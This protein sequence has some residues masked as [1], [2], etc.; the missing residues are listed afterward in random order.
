MAVFYYNGKLT[1]KHRKDGFVAAKSE[2]E[3]KEE[4]DKLAILRAKLFYLGSWGGIEYQLFKPEKIKKLPKKD[5]AYMFKQLSFLIRSGITTYEAI[6]VL[7]KSVNI[8]IARVAMQ[9]KP[10]ITDGMSLADAL[11]TTKLFSKDII[12]K[13]RVGESSNS[14]EDALQ[15]IATKLEEELELTSNIKAG[16]SYPVFS[17]VLVFAIAMVLLIA[18]VPM[19][20]EIIGEFGAKLPGITLFLIACSDAVRNYWWLF[21]IVLTIIV[22]I[23]LQLMKRV[24]MYR[25]TV[26]KNLYNMPIFGK[27]LLKTNILYM[28]SVLSELLNNGRNIAESISM[29]KKTTNNVYMLKI[30]E[31]VEKNIVKKGMDLYSAMCEFELWPGEFL[32][33]IM[34]GVRTGNVAEVLDSIYNQYRYEV[35]DELKAATDLIQP[36]SLILIGIVVGVFMIGMYAAIYCIYGQVM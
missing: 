34:I 16:L 25:Y 11:D 31:K 27:I 20:A 21:L 30:L 8:K 18:I 35:K 15:N 9:I 1:N 28:C 36:I 4:L 17:L 12:E 2:K 22:I 32:Q 5:I 6:E 29:A 23:H 7:T 14:M 33:M 26:H 19:I 13:V 3:A 24:Y 10:L